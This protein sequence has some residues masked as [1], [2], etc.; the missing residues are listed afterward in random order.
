MIAKFCNDCSLRII[1]SK[2]ELPINLRWITD[3]YLNSSIVLSINLKWAL[4]NSHRQPDIALSIVDTTM[5]QIPVLVGEVIS[6]PCNVMQSLNK[7]LYYQLLL[8]RPFC[9]D[10]DNQ[11]RYLFGIILDDEAAYLQQV[12]INDWTSE[13]LIHINRITI[14]QRQSIDPKTF[15]YCFIY[16]VIDELVN[17]LIHFEFRNKL[18]SI[19]SPTFGFGIEIQQ[20]LP[21]GSLQTSNITRCKVEQ[22]NKAIS[23]INYSFHN[24]A[25]SNLSSNTEVIVK[26]SGKMLL[27]SVTY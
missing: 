24:P 7:L 6:K 15:Y 14:Y 22:F 5:N 4:L 13:E 23:D 25:F 2:L 27:L 9:F 19:P 16:M 11:V 1:K 3:A 10:S 21:I 20:H 8:E 18:F 12:Q 17:G 26:A